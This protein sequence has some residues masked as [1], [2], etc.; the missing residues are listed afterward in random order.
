VGCSSFNEFLYEQS[1]VL[2]YCNQNTMALEFMIE[3]I[4]TI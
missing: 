3:E 4:K 1:G 2:V